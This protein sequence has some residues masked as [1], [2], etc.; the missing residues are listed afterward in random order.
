MVKKKTLVA[1][2]FAFIMAFFRF[3]F[4]MMVTKS[5][6]TFVDDRVYN[7][8]DIS[9]AEFQRMSQM[10]NIGLF[11]FNPV[12]LFILLYYLLTMFIFISVF[13][14]GKLWLRIGA[15]VSIL[16]NFILMGSWLGGE[17]YKEVYFAGGFIFFTGLILFMVGLIHYRHGFK[18]GLITGPVLVVL[19]FINYIYFG[20]WGF[21]FTYKASAIMEP[22]VNTHLLIEGIFSFVLCLHGLLFS[23]SKK[24]DSDD[25]DDEMSIESESAFASYVP[26]SMK[27]KKKKKKKAPESDDIEWQF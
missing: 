2:I 21:S 26:D 24:L 5:A 3:T 27:K 10:E 23:F 9:F 8:A 22:Y 12:P 14:T 11:G 17:V 4:F 15:L 16:G 6:D 1:S 13:D 7:N 20:S 25:D 18:L 19:G